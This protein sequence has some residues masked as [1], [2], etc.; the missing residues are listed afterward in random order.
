MNARII[1][2]EHVFFTRMSLYIVLMHLV[3]VSRV[4]EMYSVVI[5]FITLSDHLYG[6]VFYSTSSNQRLSIFSCLITMNLCIS[7][8]FIEFESSYQ[9]SPKYQFFRTSGIQ[10][11]LNIH[12]ILMQQHKAFSLSVC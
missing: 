10:R 7:D 6:I 9:I 4:H 8:I 2:Q 1:P 5:I 11:N 3:C 12:S